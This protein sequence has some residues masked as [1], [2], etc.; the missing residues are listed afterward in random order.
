MGKTDEL[1]Q[2]PAPT[3]VSAEEIRRQTIDLAKRREQ[4]AGPP[5]TVSLPPYDPTD[6]WN[7]ITGAREDYA[8][9]SNDI[10]QLTQERADSCLPDWF[11]DWTHGN[12]IWKLGR[13]L[14][15]R[16]FL[17]DLYEDSYQQARLKGLSHESAHFAAHT[18]VD[19]WIQESRFELLTQTISTLAGMAEGAA[20][21]ATMG[22]LE[23]TLNQLEGQSKAAAQQRFDQV[24]RLAERARA[25]NAALQ[26]QEAPPASSATKTCPE[27]NSASIAQDE[28]QASEAKRELVRSWEA[29][30]DL[31][32]RPPSRPGLTNLAGPDKKLSEF[33]EKLKPETGYHDVVVHGNPEAVGVYIGDDA[34]AV[35]PKSVAAAMRRT[36]YKGGPVR[37]ISCSVGKN[38]DGFAQQLADE[39][40]A[41]VIAPE[42][43]VRFNRSGAVKSATDL[44]PF[45]PKST[46]RTP[47]PPYLPLGPLTPTCSN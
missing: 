34:V 33:A 15:T 2:A 8:N 4:E 29:K 30:A 37:L 38:P 31:P 47:L 19:W 1:A 16:A 35:S 22:Q 32:P 25:R 7:F 3:G 6:E 21:S 17:I 36:G 28:G 27:T 39:I 44:K 24:K 45:F 26:T 14:S 23:N 20:I 10:R 41:P 5:P 11:W 43:N 13:R 12:P 40:G 18:A 42:T 46:G 9:L